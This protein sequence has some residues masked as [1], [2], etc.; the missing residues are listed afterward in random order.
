VF[1]LFHI[2]FC[3]ASAGQHEQAEQGFALAIAAGAAVHGPDRG[4][5]R[6]AMLQRAR[7]LSALGRHDEAAQLA[8]DHLARATRDRGEGSEAVQ[9]ARALLVE[10][11][12]ACGRSEEAAK[13]R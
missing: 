8:L 2:A 10:V 4:Q 12:E 5:T 3:E 6:S 1:L 9:K 13:W 11:Y 7:S